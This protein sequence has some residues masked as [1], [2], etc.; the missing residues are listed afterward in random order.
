VVYSNVELKLD[1]LRND[2]YTLMASEK[3]ICKFVLPPKEEMRYAH[4]S[5]AISK[6]YK[7]KIISAKAELIQ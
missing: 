7:I 1:F 4:K 6:Q 2:N 5:K 3:I